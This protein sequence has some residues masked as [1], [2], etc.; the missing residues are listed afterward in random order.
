ML[1]F[2]FQIKSKIYYLKVFNLISQVNE[3][4]FLVHQESCDCKFG[5]NEIA[6]NSKQKWNLDK[7]WCECKE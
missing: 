1:K 7:C 4:R 2:M 5:L 3:T 6:Y